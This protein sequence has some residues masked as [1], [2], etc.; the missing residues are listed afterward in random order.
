TALLDVGRRDELETIALALLRF[1][2]QSLAYVNANQAVPS[3]QPDLQV[4]GSEGRI[5][6][7]RI[8]RPFIAD[9]E[10]AVLVD[11]EEHVA[12]TSTMDAFDRAVAAFQRAVLDDEEPNA[13]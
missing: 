11:G 5:V 13:S 1:A 6:G 8:T 2:N 9:G 7:R 3:Y 4:Y 10:L 12:P